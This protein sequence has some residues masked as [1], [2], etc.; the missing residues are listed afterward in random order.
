M[1]QGSGF[2][3]CACVDHGA[4]AIGPIL[5]STHVTSAG[6]PRSA[7]M[8]PQ[9]QAA[10]RPG[11]CHSNPHDGSTRPFECDSESSIRSRGRS[12][13]RHPLRRSRRVYLFAQ[14]RNDAPR[15][16]DGQRA[17]RHGS[18]RADR[19]SV[20]RGHDRRVRRPGP[21]RGFPDGGA[22]VARRPRSRA[23]RPGALLQL[24]IQSAHGCE[25][26]G[27]G[28][29]AAGAVRNVAGGCHAARDVHR[30]ASGRFGFDVGRL[31]HH[32][33]QNWRGR[34]SAATECARYERA[35]PRQRADRGAGAEINV[36]ATRVL[37]LRLRR[38][39]GDLLW[40]FAS[41]GSAGFPKRA[42][43]QRGGPG[44]VSPMRL[45]PWCSCWCCSSQAR[46]ATSKT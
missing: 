27:S 19:R 16:C 4:L 37:R 36:P 17:A 2:V 42:Y 1:G 33:A 21:D 7:P 38:G 5:Q 3:S 30:F 35:R 24:Q 13:A 25:P 29:S 6:E 31:L 41:H 39:R 28:D 18:D 11:S 20:L 26:S 32:P 23:F 9:R 34:H 22:R 44:A 15:R 10:N 8:P 14:Q 12:L 45:R 40:Q 46:G 43:C